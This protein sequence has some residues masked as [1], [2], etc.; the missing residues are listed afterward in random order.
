MRLRHVMIAAL[1]GALAGPVGAAAKVPAAGCAPSRAATAYYASGRAVSPA[2]RTLI[3]CAT[4]TG[5]YTG[6]TGIGVTA[7][8]TVWFSAANWEWQLARSDDSGAH[9]HA[10]TVPG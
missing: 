3:P 4:D 6:E 9:W 5:Y 2:P 8:G 1:V 10:F 7:A